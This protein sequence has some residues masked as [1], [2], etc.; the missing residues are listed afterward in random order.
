MSSPA[1]GDPEA[2]FAL[3]RVADERFSGWCSAGRGHQIYGGHL[4]AQC[5]RAAADT[6]EATDTPY[7][8]H[9]SFLG[10]GDIREPVVYAT[11]VLKAGRA[12]TV[13]DVT[14]TQGDRTIAAATVSWHAPESSGTHQMSAP[15]VP[16]AEDCPALD[17]GLIGGPSLTYAPVEARLAGRSPRIDDG[18]APWL[19]QWR[20]W[21]HALPDDPLAHACAI[22]WMSD[23][24][25]TR[26]GALPDRDAGRPVMHASLDHT[27]R[28][29]AAARADTWLL[30]DET[31]PVRAAGRALVRGL[32]FDEQRRLVA[33]TDQECLMR[34]PA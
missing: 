13:I 27:L 33:S 15:D 6:V 2:L 11:R 17:L 21:S 3:E 30:S 12:F 28:F 9:T 10:P 19:R 5:I 31:S 22:A 4:V 18:S 24:S 34:T 25:M 23:L 1:L 29:H 26:T 7:A 14:A 32:V 8:A 16:A 20:R